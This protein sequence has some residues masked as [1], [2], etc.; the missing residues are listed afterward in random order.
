MVLKLLRR[1]TIENSVDFGVAVLQ[2]N[3]RCGK[4][5]EVV[6]KAR[7]LYTVFDRP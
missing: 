4:G 3:R 6:N 5:K 2:S 1:D 7:L